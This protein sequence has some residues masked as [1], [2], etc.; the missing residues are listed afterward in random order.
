MQGIIRRGLLPQALKDFCLQ[1]GASKKTNLMEWD[2]IYA[3]NRNYIDPI[4][5][6]YFAVSVEG[7]VKLIIDNIED[8]VEEVEVDWHPNIKI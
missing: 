1:Q 2:K 3:I 7:S 4:A 5:K 8:K 6:R